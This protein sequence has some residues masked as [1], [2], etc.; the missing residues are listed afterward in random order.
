[1][2]SGGIKAASKDHRYIA[3]SKWIEDVQFKS[4]FH[5][6][7]KSVLLISRCMYVSITKIYDEYSEKCHPM[8]ISYDFEFGLGWVVP[9]YKRVKATAQFTLY[10]TGITKSKTF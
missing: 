10:E 8:D 3:R 6:K 5:R 9:V 4:K 1:M 2:R 7:L